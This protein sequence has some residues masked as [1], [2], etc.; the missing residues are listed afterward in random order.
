MPGK[1]EIA[2]W[3]AAHRTQKPCMTCGVVKELDQFYRHVK[4]IDGHFNRCM[5][6]MRAMQMQR[7]KNRLHRIAIQREEN[8]R[9]KENAE[10]NKAEEA[11]TE[12]S[13]GADS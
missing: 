12:A 2:R 1:R 13:F 5:E 11:E 3:E 9:A 7:R 6:C 4:M 8:K 10:Q